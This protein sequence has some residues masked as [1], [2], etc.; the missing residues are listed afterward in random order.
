MWTE[1]YRPNTLDQV[2]TERNKILLDTIQ[3]NPKHTPHLLLHGS[4]GTGKTSTALAIANEIYNEKDRPSF[5][6]FLNASD[7]RGIDVVRGPITDFC[8]ATGIRLS[9]GPA[10]PFKFLILD[11]AD[12]MTIDA[13]FDLRHKMEKHATHVRFCFI[14]N[15][16]NK[17]HPAIRSRCTSMRF[18]PVSPQ[19]VLSQIERI[20]QQEGM[21][22]DREAKE[23]LI[24]EAAGDLRK[25]IHLLQ[26]L[27]ALKG[28]DTITKEVVWETLGKPN[29]K[30]LTPE[31]WTTCGLIPQSLAPGR[32]LS[33]FLLL[34][35]LQVATD[36]AIITDIE[37]A[38]EMERRLL[39]EGGTGMPAHRNAIALLLNEALTL[40][41]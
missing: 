17:I 21:E 41:G 34:D 38:A 19:M 37:K 3:K 20:E 24:K 9:T 2:K 12:A 6:K 11:E 35:I 16:L 33:K 36:H 32:T 4:P 31:G 7:K 5:V 39:M 8:E 30:A 15:Y 23:G 14:A 1:R 29:P 27:H 28:S 18:P 13:Q 10:Y 22:V 26:T 25:A 40:E